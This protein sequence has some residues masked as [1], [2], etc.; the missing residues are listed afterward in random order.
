MKRAGVAELKARLSAYL[1]RVKGGSEL[2]VTEHGVPVAKL[3]PLGPEQ[4]GAGRRERL[5]RAG[6]LIPGSGRVR[7]SLRKAPKGKLI[8]RVVLAALL[9]ERQEG[10]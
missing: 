7:K 3:V 5:I 1:E 6:L 10:R 4:K 9:Q 8:G 2:L